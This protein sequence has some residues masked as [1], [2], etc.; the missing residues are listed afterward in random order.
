[1][2]VDPRPE[3]GTPLPHRDDDP[4]SDQASDP[5]PRR[6][7]RPRALFTVLLLMMALV[8]GYR[9]LAGPFGRIDPAPAPAEKAQPL[10]WSG[11]EVTV[12]E[13]SPVR[14]KLA[15]A[16]VAEQD[17]QRN[18]VLPAVVEADPGRLIKVLPPLAGRVTQLKAQLGA[19]V[20]AG[21][22]LVVMDS[23][24][25][26][27]AYA[28]YDRDKVQLALTLRTRDRQ[29]GLA[30]IGG[31][32]EKDLQQAE[33]DYALQAEAENSAAPRRGSSQDRGR[34]G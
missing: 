10:I 20:E 9:L 18:L 14:A 5:A 26:A 17:V 30:K 12:P 27:S 32:A 28:D 11:R 34:S 13:R 1:M 33:S 6:R 8:G 24:D 19:R 3:A 15:I 29:R 21:E 25:L 16:P 23:A 31:A 7:A 2:L 4:A 22:P